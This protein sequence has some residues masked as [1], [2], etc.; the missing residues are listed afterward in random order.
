MPWA[1]QRVEPICGI[2][3]QPERPYD[4]S[5]VSTA[6]SWYGFAKPASTWLPS[7]SRSLQ[8]SFA[9]PQI[10]EGHDYRPLGQC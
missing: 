2:R 7:E 1:H 4:S 6:S 5:P 8:D 3:T 9:C 10:S